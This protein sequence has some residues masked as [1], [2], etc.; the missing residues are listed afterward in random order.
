MTNLFQWGEFTLN[1]GA[2]SKWKLECDALTEDDWQALAYMAWQVIGPFNS[3]QGVPRGG[4]KLAAAMEKYKCI[5]PADGL[6]ILAA[7]P[8]LPHLIVDDVLTTGGSLLRAMNA[9]LADTKADKLPR[10]VG[11]VV[12]ARGPC[13]SWV[14][15]I[16]QMPRP[17]WLGNAP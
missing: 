8:R 10:V 4:L 15:A 17:L 13:P 6:E 9:Y 16:F 12:F 11:C 7:S 14:R 2:K 1:S 3:V 5:D